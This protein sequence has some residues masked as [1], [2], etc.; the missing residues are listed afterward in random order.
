[1]LLN[2]YLASIL[3][4]KVHL[5]GKVTSSTAVRSFVEYNKLRLYQKLYIDSYSSLITVCPDYSI[6]IHSSYIFRDP[7]FS[8]SSLGHIRYLNMY[9]LQ[10]SKFLRYCGKC[11]KWLNFYGYLKFIISASFTSQPYNWQILTFFKSLR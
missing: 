11:C 6:F 7:S 9:L 2:Y 5:P 1:M 4:F 10:L 3:L 8:S